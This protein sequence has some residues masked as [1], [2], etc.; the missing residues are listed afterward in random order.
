MRSTVSL[1][2]WA[3]LAWTTTSFAAFM[4]HVPDVGLAAGAVVMAIGYG[5]YR[6]LAERDGVEPKSEFNQTSASVD[7]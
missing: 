4:V 1:V 2:L 3:L 5:R 6:W 7:A